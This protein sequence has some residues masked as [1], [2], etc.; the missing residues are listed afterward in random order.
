MWAGHAVHLGLYALLFFLPLSGLWAWAMHS[1]LAAEVHE[2]AVLLLSWLVAAHILGAATEHFVFRN[3]SLK[4]M[5]P[6][7]TAPS[8]PPDNLPAED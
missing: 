7:L 4:R 5:I 8:E 1:E 2:R 6:M 3:D